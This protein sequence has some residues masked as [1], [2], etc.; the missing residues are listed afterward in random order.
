MQPVD[1]LGGQLEF[2]RLAKRTEI[3]EPLLLVGGQVPIFPGE[4]QQPELGIRRPGIHVAEMALKP[5]AAE[6]MD[7]FLGSQ[8]KLFFDGPLRHDEARFSEHLSEQ[9]AQFDL[10]RPLPF[11]YFFK[12]TPAK[13]LFFDS[14][15]INFN[16][17]ISA[18][19][20]K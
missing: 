3:D 7:K 18:E 16:R 15:S 13:F 14:V 11:L 2:H 20:F 4:R 17:A 9:A 12:P 10:G 1:F 6:G 5:A 8:P 19:V